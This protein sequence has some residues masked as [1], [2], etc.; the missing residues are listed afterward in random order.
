MSQHSRSKRG[1]KARRAARAVGEGAGSA[2][3]AD[4]EAARAPCMSNDEAVVSK[5]D[6]L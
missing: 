5:Q 4:E 6:Q 2:V 1:G 3:T